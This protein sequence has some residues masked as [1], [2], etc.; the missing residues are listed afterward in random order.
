MLCTRGWSA[1]LVTNNCSRGLDGSRSSAGVDGSERYL[2]KTSNSSRIKL[3]CI[4]KREI[5]KYSYI[6]KCS[7]GIKLL[8]YHLKNEQAQVAQEHWSGGGRKELHILKTASLPPLSRAKPMMLLIPLVHHSLRRSLLLPALDA[9]I[10]RLFY[11]ILKTVP[12]NR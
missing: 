12:E 9:I 5:L 10:L 8:K 4:R 11:H 7:G 1:H 6:I 2:V 3:K